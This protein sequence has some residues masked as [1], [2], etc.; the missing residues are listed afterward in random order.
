MALNNNPTA[1]AA[2][3]YRRVQV[4]EQIKDHP[5]IT[6]RE[7]VGALI[8]AGIMNEAKG[9]APWSLGTINADVKAVNARWMAE[10]TRNMGEARSQM[11]A[12]LYDLREKA[13]GE[14]R[15]ELALRIEERI[16][17]LLGLDAPARTEV[18]G[19][20]GRD[21]IPIA[22]LVG[23]LQRIDAEPDDGGGGGSPLLPQASL[24]SD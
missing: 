6:Q 5:G 10:S 21:L 8:K 22:E 24:L 12:R 2:R 4:A 1:I 9:G 20:D 16:A 18:T 3:E 17:K 11:L 14:K 23:I 7:I 13:L 15:Y 19:S